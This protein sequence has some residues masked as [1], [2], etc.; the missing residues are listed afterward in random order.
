MLIKIYSE[1]LDALS[2]YSREETLLEHLLYLTSAKSFLL[3][4]FYLLLNDY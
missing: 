3:A 4:G 1:I 2:C